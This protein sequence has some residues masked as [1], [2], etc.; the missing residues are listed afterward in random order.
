MVRYG[1]ILALLLALW[2]PVRPSYARLVAAGS[3]VA[4][5]LLE[6]APET[7]ATL[8]ALDQFHIERGR[9]STTATT[10]FIGLV[11]DMLLSFFPMVAAIPRL[12]WR[13]RLIL[14]L[15]GLSILYVLQV[16]PLLA[17]FRYAIATAYL[18]PELDGAR[19]QLPFTYSPA[20]VTFY[21]ETVR[22]FWTMVGYFW[23]G[24][25]VGLGLG[26]WL[27]SRQRFGRERGAG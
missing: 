15:V 26:A 4:F 7:R 25:V 27:L 24:P 8:L 2:P 18:G 3:N 19:H 12:T 16:G 23:A 5:E 11:T 9:L 1:L 17:L 20:D 21:D 10:P 13:N 14:L 22:P 6:A